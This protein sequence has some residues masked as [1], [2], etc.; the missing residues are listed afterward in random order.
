M[1]GVPRWDPREHE[2]GKAAQGLSTR[3]PFQ[4]FSLFPGTFPSTTSC[5][6]QVFTE[7]TVSETDD[8]SE[9]QSGSVTSPA[10]P[11][12]SGSV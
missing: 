11:L 5:V 12:T 8:D 3:L 6:F 2:L 10:S 7:A 9:V 1:T 4:S